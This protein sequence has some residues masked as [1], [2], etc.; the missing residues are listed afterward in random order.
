[1][2]RTVAIF[3]FGGLTIVTLVTG[4]HGT[5]HGHGSIHGTQSAHGAHGVLGGA[6]GRL[7]NAVR[8]LPGLPRNLQPPP[9][10]ITRSEYRLNGWD[11]SRVARVLV[12]PPLNESAYTRAD[13]EFLAA[14]TGELQ[15]LGRF[16]VVAGPP[17]DCA[18]LAA[19]IHRDGTFDE[20]LMLELSQLTK[21]DV[22]V[23]VA[24]TH[25]SPYP[26]P[27]MGLVVQAVAPSQAK[28]IASVDG[29][30]DTIDAGIAEEVRRYYRQ[31]PKQLPPR[32]RNH[33]I[34]SD[35]AFAEELALDSPALFQRWVA[36][37]VADT[38]VSDQAR[39]GATG[40]PPGSNGLPM[41]APGSASGTAPGTDIPAVGVP[42]ET[43]GPRKTIFPLKS[44]KGW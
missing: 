12:L 30:W 37:V 2:R 18:R 33:V 21:A 43:C 42:C 27:R 20:S 15:R 29:L 44:H 4:C 39:A 36:H 9:A 35:D 7:L 41:T 10:P 8:S 23:H 25:Y 28:V 3:G 1:M 14:L 11:W 24:I 5:G 17:D 40:S 32:V 19:T 6:P 31:R 34:V 22:V 38:L 26:R 16:E 13:E